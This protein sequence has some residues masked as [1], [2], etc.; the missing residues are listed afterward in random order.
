MGIDIKKPR[1]LVL[2]AS[3]NPNSRSRILCREAERVLSEREIPCEFFDLSENEIPV[4][5]DFDGKEP[6]SAVDAL[7]EAAERADG[8][9]LGCPVYVYGT[10]SPL[11]AAMCF[12]GRRFEHKVVSVLA[13]AGG[14]RSY[15]SIMNTANSLQLDFRSFFVPKYVYATY[16]QFAGGKIADPEIVDRVKECALETAALAARLAIDVPWAE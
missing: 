9:M 3:L 6:G 11:K 15:M 10:P 1:V 4:Y 13:A 8:F 2:S 16:K 14:D 12:I 5:N 7:R